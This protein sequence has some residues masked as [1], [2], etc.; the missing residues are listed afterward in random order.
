MTDEA[1]PRELQADPSSR[2]TADPDLLHDDTTEGEPPDGPGRDDKGD[3]PLPGAGTDENEPPIEPH[4]GQ[5]YG[6]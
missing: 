2:E 5:V 1:D 3:D 6:G 4:D